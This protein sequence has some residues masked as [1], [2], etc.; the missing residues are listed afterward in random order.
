[1]LIPPR[2]DLHT[3]GNKI[4]GFQWNRSKRRQ[5]FEPFS[6]NKCSALVNGLKSI[7]GE[8]LMSKE[9]KKLLERARTPL[10]RILLLAMAMEEKDQPHTEM[11]LRSVVLKE[12]A[13][14]LDLQFFF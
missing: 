12:Q 3:L 11:Y 9:L 5:F 13:K 14:V 7:I 4:S 8:S 10:E 6:F 2:L 1:M